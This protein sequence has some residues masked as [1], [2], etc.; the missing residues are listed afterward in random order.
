MMG[1]DGGVQTEIWVEI[2]MIDQELIKKR[3]LEKDK[4]KVGIWGDI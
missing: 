4:S 2:L 3:G 1:G